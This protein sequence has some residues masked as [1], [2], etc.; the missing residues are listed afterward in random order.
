MPTPRYSPNSARA[1]VSWVRIDE[2]ALVEDR[3]ADELLGLQ[4]AYRRL[5]ER[6]DRPGLVISTYFGHVGSA[7]PVLADLRWKGSGSTS[8]GAPRTSSSFRR[9]VGWAENCSVAGVVDGRNVWAND[10]DGSLQLL[11]RL[12]DLS[13]EV[14]VSTSCS[15]LHVPLSLG[16]EPDLPTEVV[17]WLAFAEEKVAEVATLAKGLGRGREAVAEE[18]DASRKGPPDPRAFGAGGG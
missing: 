17:P 4:R 18:L 16:A 8:A 15:L 1:S 6:S 10:L 5:A 11:D 9:P 13:D 3:D 2:P 14:V 7:L 12:S